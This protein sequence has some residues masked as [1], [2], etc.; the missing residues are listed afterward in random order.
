[1]HLS[2]AKMVAG[3]IATTAFFAPLMVT[4]P[5]KGLPP[6]ITNL[7]NFKTLLRALFEALCFNGIT[8]T[9]LYTKSPHNKSLESIIYAFCTIYACLLGIRTGFLLIL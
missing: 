6:L 4:S 5:F 7:S 8:I 9:L 3:K 2:A 1:M